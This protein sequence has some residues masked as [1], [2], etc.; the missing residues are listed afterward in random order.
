MTLSH[1]TPAPAPKLDDLFHRHYDALVAWCRRRVRP[2]VGEP[3][4]F[5][6][7][8]YLRCRRSWNEEHRSLHNEAAYLYRAL[9]WV[10]LDA[11]RR[12]ARRACR[13]APLVDPSAAPDNTGTWPPRLVAEALD[14]LPPR[15]QQ[16]CRAILAGKRL[17]VVRGELRLSPAALA[18]NLCRARATLCER[19]GVARSAGRIRG[20]SHGRFAWGRTPA[21]AR[22]ATRAVA[23]ADS[24]AAG[25]RA[26]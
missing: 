6:H 5:V 26:G 21:R 22:G 24:F 10:V 1:R 12:H 25:R 7:L 4:D 23:A 13:E 9:R 19:L 8:A 15:Q 20:R 11:L 3:E 16:V 2:H 17:E 18:V 14:A